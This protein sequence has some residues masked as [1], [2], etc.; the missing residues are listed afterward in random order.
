MPG[1][2]IG[3]RFDKL[4]IRGSSTVELVFD[5]CKVPGTLAVQGVLFLFMSVMRVDQRTI[6]LI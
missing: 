6:N 1:F 5:D 4:G 2:T 3:T